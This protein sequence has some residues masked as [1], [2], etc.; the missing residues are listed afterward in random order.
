MEK[1]NKY[2]CERLYYTVLMAGTRGFAIIPCL[3]DNQKDIYFTLQFRTVSIKDNIEP[4]SK[5]TIGEIVI[6]H[7]PWCG[8]SLEDVISTFGAEL[9]V[10]AKQNQHLIRL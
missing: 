4:D 7:C 8:T 3:K 2:C 9:L 6:K 10:L 5:I 1:E